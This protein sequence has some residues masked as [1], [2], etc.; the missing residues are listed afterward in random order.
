MP[1]VLTNYVDSRP[2]PYES[3]VNSLLEANSEGNKSGCWSFATRIDT[4]LHLTGMTKMK[5]TD[6]GDQTVGE[7]ER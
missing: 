2:A 3:T 4:R 1:I 5:A 6:Q 7:E